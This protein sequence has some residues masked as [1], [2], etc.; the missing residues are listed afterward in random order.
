MCKNTNETREN[1]GINIQPLVELL[2][3]DIEPQYLAG[4]LEQIEFE[5][6]MLLFDTSE[7]VMKRISTDTA[8]QIYYLHQL[9]TVLKQC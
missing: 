5:Y 7:T 1:K 9:K 8:N 2:T 4:I 3:K 6:T